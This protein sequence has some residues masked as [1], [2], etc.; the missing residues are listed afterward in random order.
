MRERPAGESEEQ[1]GLNRLQLRRRRLIIIGLV[2]LGAA[3][4]AMLATN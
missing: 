1:S 4:V 2:L 3:M